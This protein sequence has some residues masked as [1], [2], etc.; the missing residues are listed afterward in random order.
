M[1][2]AAASF[3]LGRTLMCG[4]STYAFAKACFRGGLYPL[5][6]PVGDGLGG[7][8][9]RLFGASDEKSAQHRDR[10]LELVAGREADIFL[11]LAPEVVEELL[12]HRGERRRAALTRGSLER[13]WRRSPPVRDVAVA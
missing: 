3:D 6:R 11:R 7:L 13:Q 4:C 1:A 12:A 9:F 10:I 8:L 5:G 2:T